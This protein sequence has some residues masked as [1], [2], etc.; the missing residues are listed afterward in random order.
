VSKK[1]QPG[2]RWQEPDI[3]AAR[4]LIAR[5]VPILA[6][7]AGLTAM[8][9]QMLGHL[10]LVE[11]DTYI[12]V[13]LGKNQRPQLL[14]WTKLAHAAGWNRRTLHE[15]CAS[16]GPI[17]ER[18]ALWLPVLHHIRGDFFQKVLWLVEEVDSPVGSKASGDGIPERVSSAKK[19][20][21]LQ[22]LM[23]S[24]LHMHMHAT[25]VPAQLD[26][27]ALTFGEQLVDTLQ[28]I[29]ELGEKLKA[30]DEGAVRDPNGD[31]AQLL[32]SLEIG[33][34]RLSGYELPTDL[35][36]PLTRVGPETQPA[37]A[38][39]ALSPDLEV[40]R[41][42]LEST[43]PGRGVR[44]AVVEI[45][46]DP[47]QRPQI[48]LTPDQVRKALAWSI[49]NVPL[50]LRYRSTADVRYAIEQRGGYILIHR[51]LRR[52]D[53]ELP[54]MLKDASFAVLGFDFDKDGT[55]PRLSSHAVADIEVLVARVRAR[56]CAQRFGDKLT[57][58][59]VQGTHDA[60]RG[61]ARSLR[62]IANDALT[63]VSERR[64]RKEQR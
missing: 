48:W 45:V 49:V 53:P 5:D 14:Q 39:R 26:A 10:V 3:R 34:G 54:T 47:H 61:L 21:R 9:A 46:D 1:I 4:A 28:R 31:D 11:F 18:C 27:T 56:E 62:L 33:H 2:E 57:P 7:L 52:D 12:A 42:Q 6:R 13:A 8:Q 19:F 23:L 60:T 16:W 32:L 36:V 55:R 51:H 37:G 24:G 20:Q 15:K 59:L 43:E 30:L 22:G 64:K 58:G 44:R 35:L 63:V 40:L 17:L 41:K 25:L 29:S 50:D 38:F